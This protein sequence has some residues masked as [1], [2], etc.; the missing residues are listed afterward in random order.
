MK[1]LLFLVV[2]ALLNLFSIA[3][4][5][6]TYNSHEKVLLLKLNS[7]SHKYL[8]TTNKKNKNFAFN[9]S[10]HR[11]VR[12]SDFK[13]QQLSSNLFCK[14]HAIDT[15]IIP[16]IT[17]GNQVWSSENLNVTHYRNGDIIPQVSDDGKWA[18]TKTGAWCW[19]RN[20]SATYS[21]YGRLYNW[22]AVSD[23]RGLSPQG[24]HIPTN[25]EWDSMTK[26]VDSSVDT[27]TLNDWSGNLI[28]I[29]IKSEKDWSTKT[30]VDN[31]DDT[32]DVS[33]NGFNAKP[34]G[35]RS[36][37]GEFKGIGEREKWW[38]SSSYNSK[39]AWF[40]SISSRN[41][42]LRSSFNKSHG[43]HVRIVRDY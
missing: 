7:K 14:N 43:F 3:N 40:R 6:K 2:F 38:T 25:K 36:Y 31:L 21:K 1:P 24:W 19:Y 41:K 28:G 9:S 4:D 22:Y 35:E 17:L 32:D 16:I 34:G 10:N 37:E 5:T 30:E 42:I 33:T 23:K 29:F 18:S 11:K 26:E 27:T 13:K 39:F 20:D 15:A 8:V 12:L